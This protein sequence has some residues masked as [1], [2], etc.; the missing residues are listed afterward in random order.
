MFAAVGSFGVVWHMTVL[1]LAS[2][3][4][5]LPFTVSQAAATVAAMTLNFFF[6]NAFT[7]RDRR[8][9]RPKDM[10]R[11]LLSFYAVCS[12]GAVANVG[13]A[14]FLFANHYTWWLAG[15]AGTLIG[16]VWNY[17]AGSVFTWRGAR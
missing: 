7:Y 16:A 15:V 10:A 12:L 9:S 17:A 13:I 1:A 14:S 11:G 4:L 3:V 2:Q 5:G 6:N 8:L